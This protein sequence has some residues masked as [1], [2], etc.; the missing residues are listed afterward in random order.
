MNGNIIRVDESDREV[1]FQRVK[2]VINDGGVIVFPTDTFY[3][4]GANPFNPEAIRRI[5]DIKGRESN[6]PIPAVVGSYKDLC[7]LTGIA[8]LPPVVKRLAEKFW[9]GPLTIIFP[10]SKD[11]PQELTAGRKTVACRIPALTYTLDLLAF[12]GVPL[13]ST[14]ANI[15]G[16]SEP[17]SLKS[18]PAGLIRKVDLLLD[19][20]DCPGGLPSTIIELREKRPVLIREGKIAFAD[21]EEA[22]L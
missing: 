17:V 7:R 10:A 8:T 21:I 9:P 14:S 12:L 4:L 15:S 1:V 6:K 2:K 20:G 22:F 11:L 5:F 3:A 18:I 13:T 19:H 16:V